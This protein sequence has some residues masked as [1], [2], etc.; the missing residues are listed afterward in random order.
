M[1]VGLDEVE[2]LLEKL[3]AA[4]RCL[5]SKHATFSLVPLSTRMTSTRR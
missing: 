2:R 3:A 4:F 1:F 5:V